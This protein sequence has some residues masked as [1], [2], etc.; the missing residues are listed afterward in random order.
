VPFLVIAG[1]IGA[2]AAAVNMFLA[3]RA[4]KNP[5]NAESS[6]M[7]VPVRS[8]GL[9]AGLVLPW[10]I[11]GP[12]GLLALAFGIG[13]AWPLVSP[14]NWSALSGPQNQQVTDAGGG[15][16]PPPGY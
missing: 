11:G 12:L 15:P 6:I 10:L 8:I 1:L 7:G 2:G 3:N 14:W 13:S 9:A 4:A 5:G 16:T